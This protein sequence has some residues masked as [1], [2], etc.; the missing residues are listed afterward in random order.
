MTRVTTETLA[1]LPGKP[2]PAPQPPPK[3]LHA[4]LHARYAYLYRT[5][6]CRHGP[7]RNARR[8]WWPARQASRADSHRYAFGAECKRQPRHSVAAA[9][10]LPGVGPL[11]VLLF[12]AAARVSWAFSRCAAAGTPPA[13]TWAGP[14]RHS[15]QRPAPGLHA[16]HDPVDTARMHQLPALSLPVGACRSSWACR[17]RWGLHDLLLRPGHGP[18]ARAR[19]VRGRGQGRAWRG[20]EAL[21]EGH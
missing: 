11:H 6:P 19:C 21:P 7:F 14:A 10:T 20:P 1:G 15:M 17:L 2:P 5:C 13:S 3:P 9:G 18:S 12:R 4:L 16:P 8:H